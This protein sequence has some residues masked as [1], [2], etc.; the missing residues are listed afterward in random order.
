[1]LADCFEETNTKNNQNNAI[2]RK[3]AKSSR[4]LVSNNFVLNNGVVITPALNTE[5]APLQPVA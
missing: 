5:F 1:M 4:L 2:G 3:C